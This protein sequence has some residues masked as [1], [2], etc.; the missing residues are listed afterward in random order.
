MELRGVDVAVIAGYFWAIVIGGPV[1]SVVMGRLHRVPLPQVE[2]KERPPDPPPSL[3][4]HRE[5]LGIVERSLTVTAV[6]LRSP[7]P[8][9]RRDVLPLIQKLPVRRLA[10]L[11]GLSVGT[12]PIGGAR[13]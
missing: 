10:A 9:V 2:G 1:V 5:S 8:G 13:E 4:W 3:G 7:E 11:T 6:L 12:A